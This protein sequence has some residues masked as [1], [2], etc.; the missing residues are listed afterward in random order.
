MS[1]IN[2]GNYKDVNPSERNHTQGRFGEG[3]TQNPKISWTCPNCETINTEEVCFLCGYQRQP[4]VQKKAVR[5]WIAPGIAGLVLLVGIAALALMMNKRNVVDHEQNSGPV[6]E[7]E[8][9]Q[10]QIPQEEVHYQKALTHLEKKEYADAYSELSQVPAEYKAASTYLRTIKKEWGR[11]IIE[12]SLWGHAI[13]FS[14]TVTLTQEES[15]YLYEYLINK[16]YYTPF[17]TES[18]AKSDFLT[19]SYLLDILT[20]EIPN[21]EALKKLFSE[22]KTYNAEYFIKE[23]HDL[24]VQLWDLPVVQ[25]I[26]NEEWNICVWLLG[27]WKADN[28]KH[29]KFY[30]KE[31]DTEFIWTD[32][33][34]PWTAKPARTAHWDIVDLEY[35]WTDEDY[36][37]LAKVY[38][39]EFLGP[40][41]MEVY[42]YVNGQTYTVNRSET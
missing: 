14:D 4:T 35:V 41:T 8:N 39:F 1:G 27:D 29:I 26:I 30:Q 11:H 24:F 34:L 13:T 40:D 33:T 28:G 12:N 7:I 21:K 5:K 37:E 32:H 16:D 23:N 3:E 15:A 42:C 36:K 17:L 20:N 6:L 38:R 9:P 2:Q 18:R 19:R 25:S 22:F 10:K 31:N